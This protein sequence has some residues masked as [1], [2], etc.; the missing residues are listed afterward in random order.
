MI[1]PSSYFDYS[2]K[3][4][5]YT[6]ELSTLQHHFGGREVVGPIAVANVPHDITLTGESGMVYF[7]LTS[8]DQYPNSSDVAGWRFEEVRGDRKLLIVNT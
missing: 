1:L 2:R 7:H 6:Q 8:T 4:R 5:L 3:H